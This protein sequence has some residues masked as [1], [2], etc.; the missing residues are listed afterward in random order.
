MARSIVRGTVLSQAVGQGFGG[1]KS[2]GEAPQA[3][4]MTGAVAGRADTPTLQQ[5]QTVGRVAT[6]LQLRRAEFGCTGT[7]PPETLLR[8]AAGQE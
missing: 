5:G 4:A 1:P 8:V 6:A 3:I 7:I 2:V